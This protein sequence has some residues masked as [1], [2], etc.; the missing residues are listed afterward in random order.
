MDLGQLLS[1]HHEV[2]LT[3]AFLAIFYLLYK[4]DRRLYRLEIL[5]GLKQERTTNADVPV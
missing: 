3:P 1:Q 4:I 2:T 5:G